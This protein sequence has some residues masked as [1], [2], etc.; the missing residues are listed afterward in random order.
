MKNKLHQLPDYEVIEV[1][2]RKEMTVGQYKEKIK[3][4][5]AKGWSIQGY[6][7]GITNQ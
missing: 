4:F 1:V 7:K 5:K 2:L 3:V 6:Q